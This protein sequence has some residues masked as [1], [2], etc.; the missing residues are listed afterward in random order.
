LSWASPI[1]W[2]Q[3]IRPFA[4]EQWWLCALAAAVAA[5]LAIAAQTLSARRDLGAG[6][7]R[8]RP[9]PAAASRRLGSAFGLA[10]RLQRNTLAGWTIAFAVV[11]AALGSVAHSIPALLN[12]SPRIR[13]LV[14][15]FG[16]GAAVADAYFTATLA[17]LAFVASGYGI[18]AA[19][20]L[21]SEE[22]EAR[23]EPVL[24]ASVSR[25]RWATSHFVFAALGPAVALAAAALAA[26]LVHGDRDDVLR[27]LAAALV[28]LPAV[29]VLVAIALALFGLAPRFAR[30][31]WGV[32]AGCIVLGQL[33]RLLQFP[34]WAMN[35]SPFTHVPPL[36]GARLAVAPL[37]LLFAV[38]AAFTTAGV[39]GFRRRDLG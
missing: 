4:G 30:A 36:L 1:G 5:A 33:G 29:W 21:R 38:A 7:L 24:A 22:E 8:P 39:L 12:S 23:A 28:Q 19:L 25:V 26:G 20:R 37:L 9:G 17:I 18:Q 11:G 27:L 10:W 31:S 6:I 32:L 15:T 14:A 35:L 13:I 34:S 16:G 2:A 3:R